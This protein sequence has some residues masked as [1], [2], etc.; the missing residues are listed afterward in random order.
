MN[1]LYSWAKYLKYSVFMPLC[2]HELNT[3]CNTSSEASRLT[4]LLSRLFSL[5][6]LWSPPDLQ[7]DIPVPPPIVS[8]CRSPGAFVLNGM[9]E[10]TS[11]FPAD[12]SLV[13][14]Q[15]SRIWTEAHLGC[16]VG[17]HGFVGRYTWWPWHVKPVTDYKWERC[18]YIVFLSSVSAAVGPQQ[19]LS[20][21]IIYSPLASMADTWC[22]LCVFVVTRPVWLQVPGNAIPQKKGDCLSLSPW[23][24][25][26]TSGSVQILL[27]CTVP[28]TQALQTIRTT[29]V[30]HIG[31]LSKPVTWFM[32]GWNS[33]FK[34]LLTHVLK[35][36]VVDWSRGSESR[37]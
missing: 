14:N 36:R 28:Y 1:T 13:R 18:L 19:R 33:P 3:I 27:L 7:G 5:E 37:I 2:L 12:P 10:T 26:L 4:E 8:M 6:G 34:V 17:W 23:F 9:F 32:I 29:Q 24:N 15:A 22:C 21:W 16:F 35:F 11:K 20:A 31:E 25:M 30:T